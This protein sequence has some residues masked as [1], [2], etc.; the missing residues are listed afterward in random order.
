MAD[1]SQQTVFINGRFL[2]QG[3]TGVQRYA[4][5]TLAC[6]DEQVARSSHSWVLLAPPGTPDP[7]LKHIVFQQ[8]GT[9]SGHAWEQW[10][11]YRHARQ[12]LLF[13]FG[14]T[15]PILHSRQIITIHDGAVLRI[16]QAYT[17][18]FRIWYSLLVSRLARKALRVVAVSQ[19]SQSEAIACFGARADR[20]TVSTEGWQHLERIQSD[21]RI[22]DAHQ[23]RGRP[24]LLAVS[25]ASP[26]KNFAAIMAAL[27]LLGDAAPTCVIAGANNST[28]FQQTDVKS[29]HL[30]RPG[31]V[32]DG[33]LKAL[34]Q[35]AA[36][37]VFPSFY[38][39]FGIP[40]LEAMSCGCPVLASTA[41]AV[42]EVCGDAAI[43]FDPHDPE[44][45]AARIKTFFANP[46]L[47]DRLINAGLQRA[48]QYSWAEAARINIGVIE[49][50]LKAR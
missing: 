33:E 1:R 18:K 26:N 43:Y 37:F 35:H 36:C 41:E 49:N 7:G 30:I 20:I 15:G 25:S 12:G 9:R 45:L 3:V 29:E 27:S 40:P 4:R 16:P 32:S 14:F 22:L 50:A 38:E 47:R 17:A 28:I 44:E 10:D 8:V 24:F 39:G 13:S 31:Y 2:T 6:M 23:L 5:E 34:Y 11:L 42:T 48:A 19:F 46:E 21:D